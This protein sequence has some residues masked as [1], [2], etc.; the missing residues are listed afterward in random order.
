MSSFFIATSAL[1]SPTLAAVRQLQSE[2]GRVQK[3]IATGRH[4]DAGLTLGTGA[5]ASVSLRQARS[6]HEAMLQTNA[7]MA[8]RLDVG[9]T[10]LNGV[11]ETAQ[12]FL[13]ALLGSRGSQAARTGIASQ[14]KA[15]LVSLGDQLNTQLA[16]S[17]VFAGANSADK[18]MP[19]YYSATD[20]ASRQSVAAAF[21]TAFGMPQSDP[22]VASIDAADMSLFLDG[23]FADEFIETAWTATWSTAASQNAT[24]RISTE[25]F[26]EV[27]AS[28]NEQVFRQLAQAYVMVADLGGN[29]LNPETFGVVLDKA[30][31]LVGGALADLATLRADLGIVQERVAAASDRLGARN[32][33]I[34]NRLAKMEEVDPYLSATAANSIVTQLQASY[35]MTAR[36]Q[37][38]SILNYI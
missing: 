14:A 21:A 19:G 37:D 27:S 35:A 38:L 32:S 18:P 31:T 24:A 6:W 11:A 30:V 16:G 8:S 13:D 15:G 29:E 25:E 36:I 12:R 28:A 34:A 9:Q 5:A 17:Y 10:A 7:M 3:E 33:V 4:A 20:P 23:A 22:A 2:L 26:I 1:S